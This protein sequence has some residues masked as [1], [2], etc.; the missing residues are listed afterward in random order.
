MPGL[1]FRYGAARI[2]RFLKRR[3]ALRGRGEGYRTAEKLA[4]F[5][6]ASA[7]IFLLFS[8]LWI[9]SL[10]QGILQW[11][12]LFLVGFGAVNVGL[13]ARRGIQLR[14]ANM[15]SI[16][17][18]LCALLAF[19]LFS[20]RVLTVVYETDGM[21]GTFMGIVK[22]LQGQNPYVYS[23]KPFLDQFGFPSSFYTPRVDGSF[24]FHLNYPAFNFL[25]LLP[26][27][28][29]GFR[30]LRDGVLFFHILT[31]LTLF[32]VVPS[33][34]KAVS[35]IPFSLG[36]PFSIVYSFTDSVWAF[37][38]VLSAVYWNRDR[39][40]SLIMFGLAVATK[41]IAFA[42]LPFL[43]V[44]LWRETEGSKLR[45]LVEGVG[46][47]LAVYLL[48]NLPFVLT[49]PSS[50]W[51]ATV[52]PYLPGTTPMVAGGMGL[53]E[54]LTDLG[55]P[56]PSSFFTLL[57]GTV[58]VAMTLLFFL[59]YERLR[60]LMWVMPAL[61]LF[62]YHR[63]FP[64]YLFYWTFPLFAQL[65]LNGRLDLRL[66]IA[67][68]LAPL[69]RWSPSRPNLT[70][71]RRRTGTTLL[72]GLTLVAIFAGVSGAYV[73]RVTGSNVE[74]QIYSV[75]DPDNLGAATLMNV[76]LTNNQA[77]SI[78]PN[79][80]VKQ[81]CFCPPVLWKTSAR[82]PLPGSSQASYSIVA[83]DA[84]A[85]VPRDVQFR[86]LVYDSIRGELA[87]QSKPMVADTAQLGV[88]NPSF[89]WWTL[90]SATGRQVPYGWKLTL[91]NSDL[92]A[93]GISPLDSN[94][95]RGIALRLNQTSSG[96]KPLEIVLSQ[97]LL[98]NA[99]NL[100]L[101]AF[102]PS[103]SDPQS[104]FLLGA[105]L[106]DGNHNLY[107]V[108]SDTASLQEVNAYSVNTTVVVPTRL[109]TWSWVNIDAPKVWATQGWAKPA[110]VDFSI[111][112]QTSNVGVY[113]TDIAAVR[114]SDVAA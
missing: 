87:G 88:A 26:L 39:R 85:A 101:L 18:H 2:Q 29:A 45:G 72:L 58:G 36:F 42:A 112:F 105:K 32:Y 75:A 89:K 20:T 33:R 40:V 82:T 5:G 70:S 31:I 65:I 76:S 34:F 17:G 56:I 93:A 43:L 55:I 64:N 66:N 38:L 16:T 46:L 11:L 69:L 44:G 6:L 98:F 92:S 114:L 12:S 25:S 49:S 91:A 97:R 4:R 35:I 99:T 3:G 104:R 94:N 102:R 23:I 50:W 74:V 79:F 60:H 106:S 109:S 111:V 63:S 21:V 10:G 28:L 100:S 73:S 52:T 41:Q 80:F 1:G 67:A 103:G 19:Y 30:D 113:S 61:V 14:R 59:R 9:L 53:S 95:T 68:K 13:A 107:F 108:F 54:I 110:T 78:S 48:P 84:L 81:L 77:D 90:D 71:F 86:V 83:T 96:T 27:Y 8:G 37:F 47:I 57:T 7:G 24:E 15:L 22:T 51:A 62:F